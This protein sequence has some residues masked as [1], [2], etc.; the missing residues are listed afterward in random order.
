MTEPLTRV[1]DE[2][3]GLP[4]DGRSARATRTRA[5]IVDA[6]L[7]LVQAG[8][9][10]PTANRIATKAGISLRLIYHHF[11]DLESLFREA[12]ARQMERLSER[13]RP[14]DPSLPRDERI[15]T[16][17]EQRA[18]VLEWIT[19]VRRASMLQE[20][21]SEELRAARRQLL[22]DAEANLA[23]L[24]V[25][26]LAELDEPARAETLAALTTALAWGFW[27]DLR[28]T[29]RS[30]DEARAVVHRTTRRILDAG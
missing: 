15:A 16:I 5:T 1:D 4:T 20:P 11:G 29:G 7:D 6:L 17:V 14:I 23:E 9:L 8:D 26:E 24:F 25:A 13:V 28:T 10:R 2:P 22:I 19:P 18:E 30:V 3:D 12:A 21:F 27:N